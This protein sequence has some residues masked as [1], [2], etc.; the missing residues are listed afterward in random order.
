M[1]KEINV[2]LEDALFSAKSMAIMYGNGKVKDY[3]TADLKSETDFKCAI[4]TEIFVPS[5][6]VTA[7][8]TG[9]DENKVISE[10]L[11][12]AGFVENYEDPNGTLHKKLHVRFFEASGKEVNAL[13]ANEKY[14]CTFDLKVAFGGVIEV[15]PDSF[16][17]TY[18][19]VGETLAR[20]ETNGK[21]ECFQLIFP[22]VKVSAENTLTLEA[23]GD[24]TTFNLNMRVLRPADGKMMK[25][26]KYTLA[27]E[28]VADDVPADIITSHGLLSSV[29]A[30]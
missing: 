4:R 3:S 10:E 6:A 21:D 12:K 16:P 11:K 14:F 15:T 8:H 9:Q 26:F 27:E 23:D 13:N 22:K 18:Y 29:A 24:P 28:G 5:A 1:N 2:T 17:G 30:E 7:T 19:A 25:L 20:L